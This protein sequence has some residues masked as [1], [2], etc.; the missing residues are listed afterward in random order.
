MQTS[1]SGNNW[2][3]APN[4]RW[5]LKERVSSIWLGG[6]IGA[7]LWVPEEAVPS[8]NT[9]SPSLPTHS[10]Q[11]LQTTRSTLYLAQSQS[12]HYS[13]SVHYYQVYGWVSLK[14]VLC[15]GILNNWPWTGY[16]KSIITFRPG[17][18][19]CSP[20]WPSENVLMSLSN[21]GVNFKV[22][23]LWTVQV[24]NGMNIYNFFVGIPVFNRN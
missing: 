5:S 18:A 10:L 1:A 12:S 9:V 17:T 11:L 15:Y 14:L 23:K 21:F 22:G 19:E 16:V 2:L 6:R 3:R 7:R 24:E 8:G 20:I 4:S 13:L